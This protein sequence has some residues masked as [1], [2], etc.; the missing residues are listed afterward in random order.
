MNAMTAAGLIVS[1]MITLLC[2][3]W[4]QAFLFHPGG[5]RQEFYALHL[6]RILIIAVPAG[7]GLMFMGLA[8]PGATALELIVAVVFLY[9]F[10]GIS[11]L[12]RL[13]AAGKLAGL[14]LVLM[15]VLL[16]VAP[17]TILL[18]ACLGMADSWLYRAK[19]P[20]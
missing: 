8:K 13:V 5:F 3:R 7:V 16:I 4:W 18:V 11:A 19:A 15:Y 6:P 12:H 1:L 10:Q 14:W 2:A 20:E 9:V 17:Q